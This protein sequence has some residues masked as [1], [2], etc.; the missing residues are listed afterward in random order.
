MVSKRRASNELENPSKAIKLGEQNSDTYTN[1]DAGRQVV[2]SDRGSQYVADEMHF[3][4]HQGDQGDGYIECLKDLRGTD[5]RVDKRVIENAKGNPLREACQCILGSSGFDAWRDDP[6]S[7]LFWVSGSPGKGKTMLLCGIINM[8][9]EEAA[10]NPPSFFFCQSND[11]ELNSATA[12]LRGLIYLLAV[13]RPPLLGHLQ[14]RYNLAGGKLFDKRDTFFALA[15]IFKSMLLHPTATSTTTPLYIV[16]D[17]LDECQTD[18]DKLLSL[19]RQ[20]SETKP[21]C[22]K[23]IVSSRNQLAVE[24]G[25]RL[26][27]L[28]TEL[29]LDRNEASVSAAVYTFIEHQVSQLAR[30]KKYDA[31]LQDTVR[32]YLRDNAD[33]TFLWVS[34]VCQS[35]EKIGARKT[36]S[37]LCDFPAGLQSFYQKMLDQMLGS[38]DEDDVNSCKAILAVMLVAYRPITL[39]ELPTLA[40][41]ANEYS[42]RTEWLEELIRICCPFL[43]VRHGTIHFVHKSAKDYLDANAAA[44]IFP[45]QPAAKH[46]EIFSRSLQVLMGTLVLDICNQRDRGLCVDEIQTETD[47]LKAVRYSCVHWVDHLV[48]ATRNRLQHLQDL[49]PGG[50][51]DRFLRWYFLYW[52]EALSLIQRISDGVIAVTRLEAALEGLEAEPEILTVVKDARRFILHNRWVI[53]DT[54][55]QAYASAL[56][57][58]P[59]RSLIRM[60]FERDEPTWISIKPMVEDRWGACLQTLKGHRDWVTSVALSRDHSIF[61]SASSDQ[62]IKIWNTATGKCEKTIEGHLAWVKSLV[63][64]HDGKYLASASSDKT[65]KLWNTEGWKYVRTVEGHEGSVNSVIFSRDSKKLISASSDRTVKIWDIAGEQIQTLRGHGDWVND[66]AC[67][68]VGN[69]DRLVSASSDRTIQFWDV[70][71]GTSL[72]VLSGHS[73]WVS[74][75]TFQPNSSI[76]IASASYDQTVRIWDVEEGTCVRIFEGHSDWVRSVTLSHD[77]HR[78]ASASDDATIRI[79]DTAGETQQVLQGHGASVTSLSFTS[80]DKHLISASQDRHLKLWDTTLGGDAQVLETHYTRVD[81]VAFSPDGERLASVSDDQTIRIWATA[82]GKCLRILAGHTETVNSAVFSCSGR[83]ASA[84][85]DRTARIWDVETGN[86]IQTLEGHVDWVE[87]LVFSPDGEQLA[88]A[89]GDRTVRIWDVTTGTCLQTLA[90]HDLDIRSVTF[91]HDGRHIAS[92]SNDCTARVWDTATG[93]CVQILDGHCDWVTSV[94]FSSD[95]HHVASSSADGKIKIWSLGVGECNQTLAGH[96]GRVHAICFSH[97]GRYLASAAADRTVKIWIAATGECV[98]T[99]D[100]GI[101]LKHISF[102][103]ANSYLLTEIGRLVLGPL[104]PPDPADG[105][106]SRTSEATWFGYGLSSDRSWVT[107]HGQGMLRLPSEYQ[108]ACSA[109][110]RSM[111]A[112]GCESGRVLV[113]EFKQDEF[114]T[115]KPKG[116]SRSRRRP[117]FA[118]PVALANPPLS[119]AAAMP[120]PSPEPEGTS[121]QLERALQRVGSDAENHQL[122]AIP[123]QEESAMRQHLLEDVEADAASKCASSRT[124][125]HATKQGNADIARKWNIPD[126]VVQDHLDNP[127]DEH[128][129]RSLFKAIKR[130]REDEVGFLIEIGAN[131]KATGYGDWPGWKGT[132]LHEA[133]WYGTP[134]IIQLLLEGG[135]DKHARDIGGRTPAFRPNW[136]RTEEIAKLLS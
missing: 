75:V 111:L 69:H 27:Q 70:G 135:A 88:S 91:S 37:K 105:A 19:I 22:V 121:A 56:L 30:L 38:S 86:C 132:A 89:S 23:W 94:V 100:V 43:I 46:H 83:L 131:L 124:A 36:L 84:S 82:T 125:F 80:D 8:L 113:L 126:E 21:T 78:I 51:L 5:P 4:T 33:D 99:A 65:I 123:N 7:G 29:N 50:L 115:L 116:A 1:M 118:A 71:K 60:A 42:D 54:P 119:A 18:L 102:D 35:L 101:S 67:A 73:D 45:S 11:S 58:S 13:N 49:K 31:Q 90:G 9:E 93:R 128:K 12:V 130:Q 114:P 81:L 34:L 79:W 104:A 120:S 52:L 74:S 133:A 134:L 53:E 72:R 48:E 17:A 57:F 136:S 107:C 3:H 28:K 10:G 97:D 129:A 98:R 26:A 24:E 108:V 25:L 96:A 87:P 62:S 68:E 59:T 14:K 32:D 109:I 76:R 41:L 2:N 106:I 61:A 127:T 44:E 15:D 20:T 110:Y 55:L 16:V 117:V 63:F 122:Q 77:G 66:V 40:D 64:S 112:M 85:S 103:A 95:D 47:P 92:A 39:T 6:R